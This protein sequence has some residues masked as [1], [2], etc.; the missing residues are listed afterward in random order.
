MNTARPSPGPT[1]SA[2]AEASPSGRWPASASE[3]D[4]LV[5]QQRPRRAAHDPW[6]HQGAIVE[7]E[8]TVGGGVA[9]V[10]TIF[11]TGRECP[12]R[13]TMCDLWK[14]TIQIDTPA[15][16]LPAQVGAG[17]AELRRAGEA[18][19][20]VKLYNAG[21]FFDPRAVPPSDYDAIAAALAGIDHV[22][23]ESHPALVGTAVDRWQTTLA[24]GQ[25]RPAATLEV[26]L[27]LETAH[28]QA[29][30][31]LNKRMTVAS[32]ARAA[33]YLR[34][35]GVGVRVFLLVHPPFVPAA[36]RRAWLCRSVEFAFASGASAISLIPTRAGNG[37]VDR[38]VA[39]GM[40][41]LPTLSD[42]EDAFELALGVGGG[43]VFADLW[44]LDG[45]SR[46]DA[47]VAARRDRL[48][49][50]NLRQQRLPGVVCDQCGAS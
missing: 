15:G 1:V 40:F 30:D 10:A 12:W 7:D 20:H 26:A 13:C 32:F 16:A 44:D 23:V 5:L 29:L 25:R 19:A 28:P 50:A 34:D 24:A 18:P 21:S 45:L 42:L 14:Y 33:S 37:T 35:R 3:R 31:A 38:F 11:L 49:R 9:R 41:S 8:P 22:I 36:E 48:M 4:G 27:G 39:S 47:C 6:R 17:L 2:A 46:C 43:R